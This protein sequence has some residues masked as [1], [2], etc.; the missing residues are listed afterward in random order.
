MTDRRP[1]Q[2]SQLSNPCRFLDVRLLRGPFF[3]SVKKNGLC[4]GGCMKGQTGASLTVI[5]IRAAAQR[6]CDK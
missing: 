5:K 3:L 2:L 4:T 6:Q 1:R